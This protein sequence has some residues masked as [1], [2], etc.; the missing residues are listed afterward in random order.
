ME[1]VDV[2]KREVMQM[3]RLMAALGTGIR[4]MLRSE[5]VD[6]VRLQMICGLGPVEKKK[7]IQHAIKQLREGVR[8][9]WKG[10]QRLLRTG[11]TDLLLVERQE[12]SK[13]SGVIAYMQKREDTTDRELIIKHVAKH[14]KGLACSERMMW[15]LENEGI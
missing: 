14:C 12:W 8:I 5:W 11:K 9:E 2:R 6:G 7:A 4:L 15:Q 10:E 13:T 3:V 1:G